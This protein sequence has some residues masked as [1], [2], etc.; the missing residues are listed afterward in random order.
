MAVAVAVAAAVVTAV[1]VRL[2]FSIAA[3]ITTT[4]T[5]TTTPKPTVALLFLLLVCCDFW[6]AKPRAQQMPKPVAPATEGLALALHREERC[7]LR[8]V[9]SQG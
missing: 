2:K 1:E 7:L 3:T 6:Q 9:G 4:T 8:S 5:T